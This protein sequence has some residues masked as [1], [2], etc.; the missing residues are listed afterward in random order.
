MVFFLRAIPVDYLPRA[1]DTFDRAVMQGLQSI[2]AYKF[3]D[4]AIIQSSLRLSNGGLGLRNS[5]QHHPAAYY[6][7]FRKSRDLICGFTTPLDWNNMPH[8]AN[9]CMRLKETVP[10]FK[11]DDSPTQR[12]LSA[13]I[14]LRQK[15]TLFNTFGVRDRARLNAV[16]APRAS[17]IFSASPSS[18]IGNGLTGDEWYVIVARNLGLKIFPEEFPCPAPG[19]K[20]TMDVYGDHAL[21]CSCKG[22]RIRRHNAE[23]NVIHNDMCTAGFS[24]VLEPKHILR[25][26][27]KKKPADIFVSDWSEGKGACFDVAVTCPL[28]IKYINH[29]A[30]TQLYAAEDYAENVKIP[31][32]SEACAAQNLLC[33]PLVFE[34]FGGMTKNTEETLLR[35]ARFYCHR[36]SI[37][38]SIGITQLFQRISIVLHRHNARMILSRRM[39][40][41]FFFANVNLLKI[42]E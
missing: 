9:A 10:D 5:K 15:D 42:C 37:E 39:H 24:P 26:G 27:G 11:L 7:S 33:I 20:G 25:N 1:C 6:A 28:Q 3:D 38:N 21:V 36:L 30:K 35:T 29:A 4:N 23:R 14:D 13:R 2:S 18:K 19:C 31:K 34:S 22:D 40:I 12:D 16:S 41:Q 32:Y 8:F 17:A